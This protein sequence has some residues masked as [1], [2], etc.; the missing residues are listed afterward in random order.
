MGS[1]ANRKPPE[2]DPAALQ[3]RSS[4]DAV[5][6]PGTRRK[7]TCNCW[8]ARR[9]TDLSLCACACG[10]GFI[11]S[12][13]LGVRVKVGGQREWDARIGFKGRGGEGR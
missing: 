3:T 13:A 6:E 12:W 4:K 7:N 8:I 1:G 11:S 9:E 10:D 2:K 5:L